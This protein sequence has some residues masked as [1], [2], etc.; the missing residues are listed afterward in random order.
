MGVAKT[1]TDVALLIM[2]VSVSISAQYRFEAGFPLGSR[3]FKTYIFY[4][5]PGAST[6][7]ILLS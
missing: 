1:T 2:S 4:R 7:G 5:T 3:S 6:F